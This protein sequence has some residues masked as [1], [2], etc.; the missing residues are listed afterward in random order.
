MTELFKII[1]VAISGGVLA[2]FLKGYKKEYAMLVGL[3]TSVVIL[4][5]ALDMV[6]ALVEEF[7]K[8]TD[9]TGINREY[10]EIIVKTLGIAYISEF[11]AQLLK[12]AGENSIA[13]K[14]ELGGKVS[15]LCIT[16]PIISNF[17]EVCI[18]A[19]NSI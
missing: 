14:V 11:G 4:I 13:S 16:L 17:L 1:G 6:S 7:I 10:I 2:V 15:I 19:V 18:N 8:L 5:L 9:K 3:V 12:D